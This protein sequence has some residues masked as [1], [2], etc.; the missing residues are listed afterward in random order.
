MKHEVPRTG[1]AEGES[2]DPRACLYVPYSAARHARFPAPESVAVAAD[3]LASDVAANAVAEIIVAP[4][5]V[6]THVPDPQ[7][8]ANRNRTTSRRGTIESWSPKSRASMARRFATLDFEPWVSLIARGWIIAMI[9]LTYPRQWSVLVPGGS[10]ASRH[11]QA[12]EKRLSRA[13]GN[14]TLAIWK[15]EFQKRGAPHFH[16][17]LPV[18]P[19]IEDESIYE[20]VSRSWFEV[21]GSGDPRHLAAGT[22][23]DWTRGPL[24]TDPARVTRYFTGHAAPNG[25]SAKEYQNQAPRHWRESGDVGRFWGYWGLAR[26]EASSLLSYRDFVAIRRILRG[27][28]RSRRR[29]RIVQVQR[30][31]R[32][33]GVIDTRRV[34][35]R[36]VLGHLASGS[37]VGAS[38]FTPNGPEFAH[39]L[40]RYLRPKATAANPGMVTGTRRRLP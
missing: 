7:R 40:A 9:T 27:L 34:H 28:D 26:V 5:L 39:A 1:D 21:V 37:L 38:V 22:G 18:P 36:N 14:A 24:V 2:R 32:S 19:Q 10:V 11:L 12:F 6:R 31:N 20:W 25:R 30:V 23:I 29:T 4:G 33:T 13:T 35:R 15:R 17:L 8:P 3:A 16:L